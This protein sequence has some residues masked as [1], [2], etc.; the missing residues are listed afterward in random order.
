[1]FSVL[2]DPSNFSPFF[3]L[4][5]CLCSRAPESDLSEWADLSGD[6]MWNYDNM[7]PYFKRLEAVTRDDGAQ[8]NPDRGYDGI[9]PVRHE[10]ISVA[11]YYSGLIGAIDEYLNVSVGDQDNNGRHQDAVGSGHVSG[12]DL[13]DLR[14]S[15]AA[16]GNPFGCAFGAAHR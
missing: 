13:G 7:L 3:F 9:I 5:L 10:N 15:F 2:V 12:W 8:P 1:M 11:H 4:L 14:G 6:D 16:G